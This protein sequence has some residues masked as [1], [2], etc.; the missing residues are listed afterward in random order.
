VNARE[1]EPGDVAMLR[2][3]DGVERVAILTDRGELSPLW[4]AT[5]VDW[6]RLSDDV[7]IRPLAVIDPENREEVERLVSL[8][9][10]IA[11][12]ALDA[13]QDALREFADP[14]PSKP[15]EPT[16]IGAV[17]EDADGIRWVRCRRAGLH[18]VLGVEWE[19]ESTC[20]HRKY[21]DIPVVR[22][23]SEGWSE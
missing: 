4:I 21:A 17:V 6:G 1:W 7:P 16:A 5:S 20:A 8:F 19:S 3:R 13:M 12:G 10:A 15:A 18:G 14:K 23:L 2:C 22:V 9:D 11:G